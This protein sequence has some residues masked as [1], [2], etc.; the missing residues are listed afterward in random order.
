MLLYGV[1]DH[2]ARPQASGAG[3]L[4]RPFVRQSFM[5]SVR[6]CVVCISFPRVVVGDSQGGKGEKAGHFRCGHHHGRCVRS[7]VT[8]SI[9][10][11]A[12][13]GQTTTD[14]ESPAKE[15]RQPE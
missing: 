7:T 13:S 15:A 6:M 14:G 5:R 8:P 3:Q 12:Q 2:Q 9:P 4:R 10:G 11:E 1:V